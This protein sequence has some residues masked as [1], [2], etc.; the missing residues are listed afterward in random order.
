MSPP[1]TITFLNGMAS[2][3]NLGLTHCSEGFGTYV[4]YYKDPRNENP[5][6]RRQCGR[7]LVLSDPKKTLRKDG[8][9]QVRTKTGWM[10]QTADGKKTG[11]TWKS[12]PGGTRGDSDGWLSWQPTSMK[13]REIVEQMDLLL[14]GGRLSGINKQVIYGTLQNMWQRNATAVISARGDGRCWTQPGKPSKHPSICDS[15]CIATHPQMHTGTVERRDVRCCSNTAKGHGPT[16]AQNWG[17]S[18]DYR[19]TSTNKRCR[20]VVK[21]PLF[22]ASFISPDYNDGKPQPRDQKK[23]RGCQRRLTYKEAVAVCTKDGARLCTQTEVEAGCTSS[24]DHCGMRGPIWTS[25]PCTMHTQKEILRLGQKMLVGAAEFHATNDPRPTGK[26]RPPPK[27]VASKKRPYKATV[28]VYQSGGADSFNVVVPHSGCHGKDMYAEYLAVRGPGLALGKHELLPLKSLR[29][30]SQPCD[31]FGVHHK[32]PLFQTLFNAGDLAWVANMGSLIEPVSKLEIKKK[33]KRVPRQ[34]FSH[35]TQTEQAQSVHPQN[36]GAKGILGRLVDVLTTQSNPY[37]T[38]MFSIAGKAKAVEGKAKAQI[39]HARVGVA[40]FV[41]YNRVGVAYRNLSSTESSSLFANMFA[42]TLDETL[43]ASKTLGKWLDSAKLKSGRLSPG[44]GLLGQLTQVARLISIR[45][46]THNE[47]D[48][49][50][51]RADGSWDTHQSEKDSMYKTL[52]PSMNGALTSF[53]AE[54]KAQGMWDNVAIAT[55]SDF[56]RTMTS[57]GLGT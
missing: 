36:L 35:N 51:V 46:K 56:G 29:K 49:F 27:Q 2:L 55:F 44:G 16:H 17:W 45:D 28:V 47:R 50:Y 30:G 57:N 48:V 13:P 54:M 52:A 25:T 3:V 34:L 32:F 42:E 26:L 1:D 37:R 12:T 10:F 14:T 23:Q 6:S 38:G 43:K 24:S 11:V 9:K 33:L 8:L 18:T 21:Y 40:K 19:D 15:R 4:T 39:I 41:D 5:Q 7:S 53:V 20:S 31:I 22:V